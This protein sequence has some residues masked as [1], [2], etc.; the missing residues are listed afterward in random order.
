MSA[1]NEDDYILDVVGYAA[2]A[3]CG[4][5]HAPCIH[6]R[7][8]RVIEKFYISNSEAEKLRVRIRDFETSQAEAE[9]LMNQRY[10]GW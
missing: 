10:S 3:N 2:S 9:R 7:I 1:E 4:C 6:D 8:R 5:T